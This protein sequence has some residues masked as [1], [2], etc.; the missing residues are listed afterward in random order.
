MR[1]PKGWISIMR[2]ITTFLA[3]A[4]LG[5][6]MIVAPAAATP[7]GDRWIT[8]QQSDQLEILSE[9]RADLDAHDGVQHPA[10]C[11]SM[12]QLA[13][14]PELATVTI[15]P[16]AKVAACGIAK[17]FGV[18]VVRKVKGHWTMLASSTGAAGAK[19]TYFAKAPA[20]VTTLL[21]K[22]GPCYSA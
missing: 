21:T 22:N 17:D 19:C 15:R 6:V 20:K 12:F 11:F 9:L 8:A 10:G 5:S 4:V 1:G 13:G 2:A 18:L 14:H 3:A 7:G 16:K